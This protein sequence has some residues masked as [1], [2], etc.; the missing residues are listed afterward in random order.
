MLIF[1]SVIAFNYID[2]D[3]KTEKRKNAEAKVAKIPEVQEYG[4]TKLEK[5]GVKKIGEHSHY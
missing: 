5:V 2:S 3:N 1:L 4:G